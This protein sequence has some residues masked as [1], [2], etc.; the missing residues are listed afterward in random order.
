MP[1]LRDTIRN[2]EDIFIKKEGVIYGIF[3]Q[4]IR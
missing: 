4:I 3:K 2:K 1:L